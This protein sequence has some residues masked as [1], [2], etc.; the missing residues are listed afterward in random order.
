[1]DAK[2]L[3]RFTNQLSHVDFPVY[4]LNETW[5]GKR[6]VVGV[7]TSRRSSTVALLHDSF[8]RVEQGWVLVVTLLD[9]ECRINDATL[10]YMLFSALQRQPVVDAEPR[11]SELGLSPRFLE[12]ATG[13]VPP[14]RRSSVSAIVEDEPVQLSVLESGRSWAAGG[15]H[16]N[17]Q[18]LLSGNDF[19]VGDV[20]LGIV[21]DFAP[22]LPQLWGVTSGQG[23][24][25]META[26]SGFSETT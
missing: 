23:V 26:N 7:H 16:G 5:T 10:R 6:F 4:G 12:S 9:S 20:R 25:Y 21:H 19:A 13:E 2:W 22:Y 14:T 15:L 1:M 8:A 24:A 18:L 3:E 11:L 17:C